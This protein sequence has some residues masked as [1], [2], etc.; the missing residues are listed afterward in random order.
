[1]SIGDGVDGR[2]APEVLDAVPTGVLEKLKEWMETFDPSA[3]LQLPQHLV[4]KRDPRNVF[5]ARLERVS[6]ARPDEL[7]AQLLF[8][9]TH[10]YHF[11]H[12][13]DHVPGMMLMEAGRQLG[14][15]VTHLFYGVP[16]DALFVLN[17]VNARFRRFAE[18]SEPVFVYSAVREKV[19]RRG[20]LMSMRQAGIFIQRGELLGSMD[21]SW[22]VYDRRLMERLRRRPRPEDGPAASHP[23]A[24]P[25]AE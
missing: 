17:D 12:P 24:A 5:I 10:P 18:L 15:A 3:R 2:D 16:L 20:R 4:H 25:A 1:M 19:Y 13:Q 14:L 23:M 8:D 9:P 7:A 6:E 11:E 21:G 22:S